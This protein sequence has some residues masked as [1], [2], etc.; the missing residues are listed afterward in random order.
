LPLLTGGARDAPARH[1]TL[2][3]ALA[4]SYDHLAGDEQ[5][6]FRRLATFRGGCTLAA[7][8]AVAAPHGSTDVLEGLEELAGNSLLRADA[9]PDGEPR[10]RML[11]TIREYAWEHLVAGGEAEETRRRHATFYL[12]LAE[13][14]NAGL[15]GPDKGRWLAQLDA[16]HEN[17]RQALDWCLCGPAAAADGLQLAVALW[18]F[19]LLH[20]FLSEGRAWLEQALASSVGDGQAAVRARALAYAGHAAWLQGD[21]ARAI[22]LSKEGL[23][24]CRYAGQEQ[25]EAA[26]YCRRNL[27]AAAVGRGDYARAHD[28]AEV[29]VAVARSMDDPRS[30]AHALFE[31]GRVAFFQGE[32]A[33]ARL[34]FEESLAAHRKLGDRPM[35]AS[36]LAF[37]GRV[38]TEQG[39]YAETHRCHAES[40]AIKRELG[41]RR[42]AAFSLTDLALAA[43]LLGNFAEAQRLYAESLAIF[44]E[45]GDRH[46]LVWALEGQAGLLAAIGQAA[47]A[48]KLL[49]AA[50]ALRTH[51]GLPLPPVERERVAATVAAAHG[52]LGETGFAAEWATGQRMTAEQAIAEALQEF[53]LASAGAAGRSQVDERHCGRERPEGVVGG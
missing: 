43:C 53:D 37:L 13:Q 50:T 30:L 41:L 42:Q 47:P 22:A 21:A 9:G 27:V 5:Q 12:A 4:W 28:L 19:W 20:G 51:A 16:E 49:G 52:S 36:V 39:D 40:L 10:F 46:N 6:V 3:A 34:V 31:R 14:A 24:L 35:V 33:A 7:A 1:Q 8:Q 29:S 44:G 11:E 45:T 48:A 18:R 15:E 38:A 26:A 32:L 25:G 17:L 2:R 23:E